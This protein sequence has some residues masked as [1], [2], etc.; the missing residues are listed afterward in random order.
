MIGK[1]NA[2]PGQ[3]T[4]KILQTG[5]MSEKKELEQTNTPPNTK[6]KERAALADRLG[7]PSTEDEE[8][9]FT[10]VSNDHATRRK[11]TVDQ[12]SKGKG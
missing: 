7:M 11:S 5:K 1:D 4:R 9:E 8:I 12:Y 3:T 6:S 10:G 2:N